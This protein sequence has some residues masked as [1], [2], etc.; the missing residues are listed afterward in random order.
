MK[1]KIWVKDCETGKVLQDLGTC[2]CDSVS[3]ALEM[4]DEDEAWENRGYC[5][6]IAWKEIV[7]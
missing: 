5:A 3:R 2:L 1:I 4:Y 7:S 6:T